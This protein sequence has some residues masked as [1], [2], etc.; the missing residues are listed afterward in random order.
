MASTSPLPEAFDFLLDVERFYARLMAGCAAAETGLGGKLL[1]VGE[2]DASA[3]ALLV[4]ANTAGAASLT[5]TADLAAQKQAMRDG[6]VDFLVT[7]LDEA[8]RILKNE[9][10]KHETVA[11]CVA[12]AP[13]AVEREMQERGVLPDLTR[14][15]LWQPAE[16]A[17]TLL[18]WRVT[19][20]P[21]MWLPYLDAL[22][23]SCL[24]EAAHRWLRQVP[25]YLGRL[26]PGL[27]V[28]RCETECASKFIALVEERVGCDE[29]AVGVEIWCVSQG[30]TVAQSFQPP[31]R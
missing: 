19:K 9:V 2:L 16:E 4:A 6:V 31:K 5:A 13:D 7:S 12:L 20:A 17:E 26:A 28:L 21:A 10:R 3:R 25:R 14:S 18:A 11:V 23:S 29:I 8:L 1:Y 27:R 30:E 22:A 15:G 24:D